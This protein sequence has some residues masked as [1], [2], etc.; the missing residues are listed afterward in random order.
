MEKVADNE[1]IVYKDERMVVFDSSNALHSS[2]SIS[3]KSKWLVALL[4]VGGETQIYINNEMHTVRENDILLCSP[5]TMFEQ[6]ITSPDFKYCGFCLSPSYIK[7]ISMIS[8]NAWNAILFIEN[9]PVIPL[10][11]SE[12]SLFLQYYNLIRTKLERRTQPHLKQP[13][14]ILLQAFIYEIRDVMEKRIKASPPQKQ[15]VV[16]Y[17]HFFCF[18]DLLANSYPKQRSVSYYAE[19]LFLTPKYLSII[20]KKISGETASDV[21]DRYVKSDIEC[22][23]KQPDKSIKEIANELE[24]TNLSFFAKYVKRVLG[25]S[26]K[27][28]RENMKN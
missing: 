13:I 4:C 5:Q 19:K 27:E 25:V 28:Y 1:S 7:R 8:S 3:V 17:S 14:D 6:K 21:I 22:L 9:S 11:E 16:I 10:D 24:F 18:L 2:H 20:C 12:S 23:L 26:P 15:S